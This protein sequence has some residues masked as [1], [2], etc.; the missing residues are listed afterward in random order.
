MTTLWPISERQHDS[1]V[2]EPRSGADANGPL[3]LEL[4]RDREVGVVVPV[5]LIGDV[6]VVPGPQVVADLDRR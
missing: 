6:D 1:T 5:V 3:R 4:A 2:P